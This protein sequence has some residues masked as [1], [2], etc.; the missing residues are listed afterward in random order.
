VG[1]AIPVASKSAA[2]FLGCAAVAVGLLAPGVQ[3]FPQGVA[4]ATWWWVVAY[5]V[6]WLLVATL[7]TQFGVT[8]LEAGRASIIMALELVSA[9]VSSV[10][11]T[12]QVLGAKESF[13]GGLIVLASLVEAGSFEGWLGDPRLARTTYGSETRHSNRRSPRRQSS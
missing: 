9:A 7:G 6:G 8:H 2:V 5:G 12:P 10:L 13:G 11:L 1:Q 3:P 4:T